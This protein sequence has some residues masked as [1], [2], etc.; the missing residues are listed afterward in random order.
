ML[1]VTLQSR[2]VTPVFVVLAAMTVLSGCQKPA[3][4]PPQAATIV[5]ATT[6][7]TYDSGLIDALLPRFTQQTGIKVK[8]V[9]VGSG[10]AMENG[11]RGDADV[12]IVHSPT[13][14][15]EFMSGGFGSERHPL[16]YNDFVIV[17]PPDDS[18][19]CSA[20]T[21]APEALQMIV[22]ASQSFVSRG[23]NS[24]THARE[25]KLWEDVDAAPQEWWNE[26]Y[27][28][29]GSG[30][31][32]TLTMASEK[33]AFTLADRGTFLTHQDR[34]KL[35][36]VFEGGIELRNDYHV[37]LVNPEKHPHV[38]VEA[39][40]Q[41]IQFLHSPETRELIAHFGEEKFGQPL[42]F[43]ADLPIQSE[44]PDQNQK[45]D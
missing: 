30:M 40:R 34:L 25:L 5:L 7:S 36:I 39:V 41:F 35:A 29:S 19:I 6:T 28:D 45:A 2:A 21:S 33:Q 38:K 20:A 13:A 22:A 1:R 26:N 12:L 18:A 8:A 14:E 16:M 17:G 37:I 27:I 11:R 4:A 10:Q 9:A 42:F 23:D 3:P 44:K 24:G 32:A 31:A 15:A 43:L